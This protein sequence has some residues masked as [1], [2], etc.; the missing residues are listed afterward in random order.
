[1][2]EY[3]TQARPYAKALF[4]MAE[5]EQARSA[6]GAV[7]S[8]LAEIV[9]TSVAAQWLASPLLSME[10]STDMLLDC[11]RAVRP[12][13][14]NAIQRE[15]THFLQLLWEKRRLLILPDVA[16]LFQHYCREAA[17]TI[18]VQVTS[19]FA[20]T[21]AEQSAVCGALERRF[22]THIAATFSEDQSL[23]GGMVI[24]SESWVYDGSVRNKLRDWA[25]QYT[26]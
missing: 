8:V 24:R 20:L 11:V 6:W 9:N 2:S 17:K 19:A 5:T 22:K 4:A 12:D 25:L 15:L 3:T 14:F 16:K 26:S 23:I 18:D 1:M 13:A 10:A 21:V 7:L